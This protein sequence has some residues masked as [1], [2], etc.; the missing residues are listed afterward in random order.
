MPAGLTYTTL[1]TNTR[2]YLERG[3]TAES[4]PIVFEMLPTL[5]TQAERRCAR[6]LKISGF[7][8]VVTAAM[9]SGTAVIAKPDRWKETISIN[10]GSGTGNNTRNPIL[11]R[12]YEYVRAYWPD[13]TQTGAP[14]FY[15][16]YDFQHIIVAPTPDAAYPFE[17]LYY[18]MVPLLDETTQTN[19]LTDEAPDLLQY[20]VLMEAVP[21]LKGDAER[22]ALWS[23]FYDRTASA[24]NGEDLQRIL[25]RAAQRR[26]N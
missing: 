15:A 3:F 22:V 14:L 21:F 10:Y 12:S 2:N 19:W 11:P 6:E 26:R 18:Q 1:L 16:D 23:Q 7:Q 20:A 9:Q 17:M 8:N 4:D 24:Y 13:Q 5:V 25:D